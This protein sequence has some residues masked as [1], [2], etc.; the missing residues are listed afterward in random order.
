MLLALAVGAAAS[1]PSLSP[2]DQAAI[3]KVLCGGQ[4]EKDAQG[5]ICRDPGTDDFGQPWEQRW[6]GAR[7]GR[8]AAREDEWLVSLRRACVGGFCPAEAYILRKVG[9]RWRQTH[10]LQVDRGID[11]ECLQLGG[12]SDGFDRL[13]C[14]DWSG[15]NQG[16]MFGR[17]SL[18]SF[19]GGTETTT[20]L[21]TKSQGG[22]CFLADPHLPERHE[23]ALTLQ[24]PTAADPQA[25]FTAI[26]Q[27][28]RGPCDPKEREKDVVM[29]DGA[30]HVL[31]FL[32]RGNAVVPDAAT[33]AILD[34]EGWT[35]DPR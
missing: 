11:D 27:I 1:A 34:A 33:A 16:F 15:P 10:E 31:R 24:S 22:E 28:R 6:A 13:A 20:P 14:L 32:R 7:R 23:D 17:L 21:M 29:T 9:G 5:W 35:P 4:M 8:F 19:A 3:M 30:R 12:M 2:A 26:L 25:A 18:R